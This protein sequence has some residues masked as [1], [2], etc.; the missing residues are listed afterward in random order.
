MW[1]ECRDLDLAVW[2]SGT[3]DLD[4]LR[5]AKNSAVS[6]FRDELGGGVAGHQVD[7][8]LLSRDTGKYLGRLCEF[9]RCPMAGKMECLVPGCGS[10]P[11]LRR[12]RGFRWR[13]EPIAEDRS[14]R[15]FDRNT[16]FVRRASS[17]PLSEE[18]D[19]FTDSAH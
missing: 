8:F 16:G 5:T 2:L 9:K 7:A 11:F 6:S 12:V 18:D 10:T 17:L 19:E 15:L 3:R 1:H 13:R 4:G 14:V